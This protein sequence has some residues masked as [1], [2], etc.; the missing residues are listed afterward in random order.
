[1]TAT[2]TDSPSSAVAGAE[3]LFRTLTGSAPAG[4]WSAPDART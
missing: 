1:M 3:D 2:R 4:V